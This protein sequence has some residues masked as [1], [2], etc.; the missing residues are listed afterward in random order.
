[1]QASTYINKQECDIPIIKPVV[2]EH[3]MALKTCPSCKFLN[4]A[5]APNGLTKAIQYGTNIK[6]S[7]S[8]LHYEQF[9]PIEAN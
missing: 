1:V 3:R 5:K 9:I 2:T 4:T 7:I 8:Y 6:A